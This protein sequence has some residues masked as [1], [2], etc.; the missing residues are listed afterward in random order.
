MQVS[1]QKLYRAQDFFVLI[2]QVPIDK[3]KNCSV[4]VFRMKL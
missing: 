3:E 2:P 1:F 4:Y